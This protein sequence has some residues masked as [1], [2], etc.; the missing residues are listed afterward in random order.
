MFFRSLAWQAG[1]WKKGS[2]KLWIM[3]SFTLVFMTLLMNTFGASEVDDCWAFCG[4]GKRCWSYKKC[5]FRC[6][7]R[8]DEKLRLFYW[9]WSTSRVLY[10][11]KLRIF[12]IFF[13]LS[14][15]HFVCS[16][17][18]YKKKAFY[19]LWRLHLEPSRNSTL[20]TPDNDQI[21]KIFHHHISIEFKSD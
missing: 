1:D 9:L 13:S 7:W 4:C 3:K 15:L 20:R 10:F 18:E 5:F 21:T 16:V 14:F 12:L 8:I 11:Q 6:L 2:K 19:K 17:S